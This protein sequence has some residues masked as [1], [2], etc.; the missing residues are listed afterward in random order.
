MK[1]ISFYPDIK[2]KNYNVNSSN[3]FNLYFYLYRLLFIKNSIKVFTKQLPIVF[4][5]KLFLYC[6]TSHINKYYFFFKRIIKFKSYVLISISSNYLKIFFSNVTNIFLNMLNNKFNFFIFSN[7][8]LLNYFW[9]IDLVSLIKKTKKT[10]ILKILNFFFYKNRIKLLFFINISYFR[11]LL[12]I[13]NINIKKIGFVNNNINFFDYYVKIINFDNIREFYINYY[14]YQI[15]LNF[16]YNKFKFFKYTY[17]M[18]VCK[19]SI[20]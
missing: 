5:Y 14:I 8:K 9:R 18:I 16:L 2:L 10:K 20:I 7:F 3:L 19:K 1:Y 17:R 4:Q 12:T 11:L 6:K 15:Y 13:K